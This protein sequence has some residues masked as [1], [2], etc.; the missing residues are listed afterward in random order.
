MD[1]GWEN[2][3]SFE[4]LNVFDGYWVVVNVWVGIEGNIIRGAGWGVN[5]EV[6][7]TGAG[8]VNVVIKRGACWVVVWVYWENDWVD[9]YY[10]ALELNV[11]E[12]FYWVDEVVLDWVYVWGA[13]WVVKV[14]YVSGTI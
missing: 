7:K 12:V 1:D 4:V 13:I 6:N 2:P 11:I 3:K 10:W 8:W 14:V 5:D 9:G